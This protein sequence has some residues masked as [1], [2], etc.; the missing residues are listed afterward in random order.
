MYLSF[1]LLIELL[2]KVIGLSLEFVSDAY[3]EVKNGQQSSCFDVV[4]PIPILLYI[5]PLNYPL[6]C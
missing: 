2:R 5:E 6:Q 3:S 4:V 1:V